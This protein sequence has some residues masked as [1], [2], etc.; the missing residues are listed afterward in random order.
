M[1]KKLTTI[2]FS[3]LLISLINVT[4]Y[5][6][7]EDGGKGNDFSLSSN[8]YVQRVD[9]SLSEA[10]TDPSF[11]VAAYEKNIRTSEKIGVNAIYWQVWGEARWNPYTYMYRPVGY[12]AHMNGST[13]LSTYHYTR[14]F[15]GFT[16]RLFGDSGRIWGSY[17]VMAI[18]GDCS[19]DVWDVYVHRVYYGTAD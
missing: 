8:V 2:L 17:T 15:L 12:S 10:M 16:W 19:Q 6:A 11:S 9:V 18:G 5:A 4:V 7:S 1:K 13:V 3:I 14:T